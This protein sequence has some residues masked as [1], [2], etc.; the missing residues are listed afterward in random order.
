[1]NKFLVCMLSLVAV[2]TARADHK[3]GHSGGGFTMSGNIEGGLATAF[4]GSSTKGFR[5]IIDN[6]EMKNGYTVSDK[7]KVHI[8]HGF[9]VNN[10]A[11]NTASFAA[12]A[13]AGSQDSRSYY[14][15]TI[16]AAA[17]L[18]YNVREA[19]V[20][21]QCADKITTTVGLF[22][23]VFGMENMWDRFDMH[24]YY[25]S[26]A[27]GVWQANGWNYNL[28]M[29]WDIYGLEATLFQ[30]ANTTPDTRTTPGIALRYKFDVAGG[31]WTLT[32]VISA[33]LGKWF[34]APKDIG[35][36][37]GAMWKMGTLWSNLEF[38]YGQTK[39]TATGLAVAKDW[40][41][42]VEPGFDLGVANVSAK[43]EL[44]S[45]TAAAGAATSDMNVSLAVS[46]AYDKM[47][48]KLLY[49]HANL[50]GKLGGHA[51]EIRL[52]F[53]AEW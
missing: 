37:G 12:G 25:Y 48:A 6:V 28:G 51:N 11:G 14:G 47:R 52:L 2:A 43:W 17:G 40:S 23:N 21:H 5:W 45:N 13:A 9:A 4:G 49:T 16:G 20:T 41:L 24:T 46:K 19:Y 30:S 44:T 3:A 27:Y 8:A 15:A 29:K 36:S 39:S 32:P 33:Y 50:G 10:G 1:M 42:I 38:E 7:T 22:R 34:G 31:D 35:F 53:G 18:M 26:R